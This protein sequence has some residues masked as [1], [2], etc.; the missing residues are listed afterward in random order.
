[1]YKTDKINRKIINLLVEDGRM[2]S[3]EIA[4][5]LGLSERAVRYRIKRLVEEQV[6]QICA[7]AAPERLGFPVVADV[8]I[9]VEPA[10]I[11]GVANRLAQ[12]DCVSYVGCAI[13]ETDVSIQVFAPDNAAVYRFVTE[14]IAR[15][16]GVV[17]TRTAILPLVIKASHQWRVPMPADTPCAEGRQP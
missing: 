8:L 11:L 16:E 17:K 9:E 6:I 5:R 4:R 14:V 2:P 10:H 7:V 12:Y 1:M 13:G 15:L 3:A